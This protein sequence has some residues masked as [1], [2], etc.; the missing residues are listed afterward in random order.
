MQMAFV[1]FRIGGYDVLNDH[2]G[3]SFV[4]IITAVVLLYSIPLTTIVMF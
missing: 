3:K 4:K 2:G 1:E